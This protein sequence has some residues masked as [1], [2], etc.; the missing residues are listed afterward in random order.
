MGEVGWVGSNFFNDRNTV[1]SVDL[2]ENDGNS[3]FTFCGNA[4]I[5]KNP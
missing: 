2:F 3:R 4:F 1:V 5:Q